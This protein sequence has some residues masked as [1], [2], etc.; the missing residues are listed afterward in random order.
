MIRV[1][2]IIPPS[3]ITRHVTAGARQFVSA[4]DTPSRPL[5][6]EER[7]GEHDFNVDEGRLTTINVVDFNF[8]KVF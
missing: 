4:T 5:P 2:R 1:K 7:R 6:R 8:R 3:L